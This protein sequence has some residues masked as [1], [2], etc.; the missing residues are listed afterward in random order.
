MDLGVK[1]RTAV[2]TGASRGIGAEVAGALEAEGA[3]VVRVSRGEGIDVTAADAAERV[4][5]LAGGP[6]DILVNNAGTS[7]ARGLLELTDDD[8]RG[9]WELHVMGAL[10]LMRHFAPLMAERGWG[11][12]VTVASSAGKRPSLTNAAY[13]VTK[14]AQ[15]SLSR[16]FADSYAERGVLVNAVAPGAVATELWTGRRRARRPDRRRARHDARGGA[17]RP[18]RED[19]ARPARRAAGDRGRRRVPVLGA[20]VD[21]HRRGVVGRRRHGGDDRLDRQGVGGSGRR[22]TEKGADVGGGGVDPAAHFRLRRVR[23]VRIGSHQEGVHDG[24]IELRAGVA[25]SSSRAASRGE[26]ACGR[27]A[28]RSSRRRRRRRR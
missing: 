10:R 21:R 8:W 5:A 3:R 14:A 25:R 18:G 11:R 24:G 2:V 1:G 12:I 28:R 6:V 23:A 16:V 17:R 4:A 9:Q 20:R 26:R 27:R 7:F 22:R 19:P 15:L 13:S